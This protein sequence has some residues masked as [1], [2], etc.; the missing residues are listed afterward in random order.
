MQAA[1]AEVQV[2]VLPDAP[3]RSTT[4]AKLKKQA[5]NLGAGV[6]KNPKKAAG[7]GCTIMAVVIIVIILG[8]VG[9][10]GAAIA[11]YVLFTGDIRTASVGGAAMG[12]AQ[13]GSLIPVKE[14]AA[15][16]ATRRRHLQVATTGL[17]QCP[18]D[19][20]AIIDDE[21]TPTSVFDGTTIFQTVDMINCLM[22]TTKPGASQ[23]IN[24]GAYT[25]TVNEK[26]CL[27]TSQSGDGGGGGGGFAQGAGAGSGSSGSGATAAVSLKTLAVNSTR[28][29]AENPT[30][31]FSTKLVMAFTPPPVSSSS[32]STTATTTTASTAPADHLIC[33]EFVGTC[34]PTAELGSLGPPLTPH[35]PPPCPFLP[36]GRLQVRQHD[37]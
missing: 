3:Q 33:F 31:P 35:G 7:C 20:Q 37:Q 21:A 5:T 13:R 24:L 29:S 14:A 16:V 9:V 22:S 34:S 12:Q 30:Q 2:D 36:I 25:A 19:S 10:I 32:G 17:A 23:T 28:P 15:T 1:T 4:R 18:R 27:P 11:R 26:S 6:K 8:A